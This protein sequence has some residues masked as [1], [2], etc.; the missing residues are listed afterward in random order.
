M[1]PLC[2]VLGALVWAT[3][4][5]GRKQ[6]DGLSVAI[7]VVSIILAMFFTALSVRPAISNY[8]GEL[9][10]VLSIR[11]QA[12]ELYKPGSPR[13]CDCPCTGWWDGTDRSNVGGSMPVLALSEVVS[14]LQHADSIRQDSSAASVARIAGELKIPDPAVPRPTWF[15]Q[16]RYLATLRF[17]VTRGVCGKMGSMCRHCRVAARIHREVFQQKTFHWLRENPFSDRQQRADRER[18]KG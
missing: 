5:R 7:A 9:F 16:R 2:L 18:R 15:P 8:F 13:G 12:D 17:D 11:V 14:K 1:V 4:R 3:L 6:F 10:N